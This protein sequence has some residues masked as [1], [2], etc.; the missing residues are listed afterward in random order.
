VDPQTPQERSENYPLVHAVKEIPRPGFR[1]SLEFLKH[2]MALF[3]KRLYK[4]KEQQQ[5]NKLN[6]K[7]AKRRKEKEDLFRKKKK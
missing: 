1:G 3:D 2:E 7:A 4:N 5:R 6:R